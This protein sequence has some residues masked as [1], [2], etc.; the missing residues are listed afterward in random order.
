[1]ASSE[2]ELFV[3][4]EMEEEAKACGDVTTKNNVLQM[5]HTLRRSAKRSLLCMSV[6]F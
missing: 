5:K 6:P 3:T 4:D 2:F 1:M